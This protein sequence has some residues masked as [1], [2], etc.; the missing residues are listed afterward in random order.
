MKS[1]ANEFAVALL[2]P[3][4]DIRPYFIARKIDL[5]RLAAMKPDWKVSI[6]AL[7]M[8]AH[9]LKYL[10]G[11]QHVYLWKQLSARG[12]RL[13]ESP[14]LD[15]EPEVPTVLNQPPASY[16]SWR[17][18]TY[19]CSLTAPRRNAYRMPGRHEGHG[20]TGQA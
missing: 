16:W 8:R 20:V 2:M 6:A 1:E 4:R 7:L 3:E 15:F 12:Y 11:K 5:E 10:S 14:E 9:R 19:P 18:E 17:T 13:C